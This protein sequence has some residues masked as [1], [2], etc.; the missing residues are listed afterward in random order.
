MTFG[1]VGKQNDT[2]SFKFPLFRW[3]FF[4]HRFFKY[5]FSFFNEFAYNLRFIRLAVDPFYISSRKRSVFRDRMWKRR[6]EIESLWA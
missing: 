6:K 2:F 5:S 4:L 1:A 3:L